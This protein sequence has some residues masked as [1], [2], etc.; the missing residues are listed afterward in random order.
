[1]H[2][3]PAAHGRKAVSVDHAQISDF[4]Q[5]K[6]QGARKDEGYAQLHG[7]GNAL[8]KDQEGENGGEDGLEE[9]DEGSRTMAAVG[10]SSSCA[11]TDHFSVALTS[12]PRSLGTNRAALCRDI[13]SFSSPWFWKRFQDFSAGS[14][15]VETRSTS[16]KHAANV[17]ATF[18]RGDVADK[19]RESP[20]SMSAPVFPSLGL[21]GRPQKSPR[22]V[23]PFGGPVCF[24]PA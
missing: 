4:C 17:E 6:A 20:V 12:D 18:A 14:T 11:L 13:P 8:A 5:D 9:E 15:L 24:C 22:A 1:M 19:A 16:A 2:D 7:E 21:T 10:N 3:A 23:L